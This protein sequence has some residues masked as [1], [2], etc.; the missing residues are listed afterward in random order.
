M[1]SPR[2][3]PSERQEA[4]ISPVTPTPDWDCR[5]CGACCREGYDTVEI[6]EDEPI[7]R[8]HPQLVSRGPFGRLNLARDGATCACLLATAGGYSCRIY[9]E[10]PNTCRDLEVGSPACRHARAKV[11][12][13]T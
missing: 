3:N 1:T 2:D 9:D 8:T 5:S 10:R 12:L 11:G 13:P 7:T 6:D 4:R